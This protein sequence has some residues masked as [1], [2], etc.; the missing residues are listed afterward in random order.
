MKALS[1]LAMILTLP[2]LTAQGIEVKNDKS[3][4][5]GV[6]SVSTKPGTINYEQVERSTQEYRTIKSE[7]VKKGSARYSI[8]I[9]QM[10]TRIKLSTEL[11]AQDEGIDCVV[12]KG[13]IRRSEYEVKDLT[14]KVIECLEDVNVTEVGSG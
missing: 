11:V 7:G 1:L 8:L 6:P 4:I 14:K 2:A 3:V 10:S 5:C 13:E 9:S 12:K